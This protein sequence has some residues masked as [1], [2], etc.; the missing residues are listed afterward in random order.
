MNKFIMI[1]PQ[2][3]GKGTQSKLLAEEFGFIHISIGDIFRWNVRNHTK[4]GSRVTRITAE[5][6]LVSDEIVENVV[7]ERLE[8]HD[9]RYGFV[10]D[11]F[12]RTP[13]QAMY[14]FENWNLDRAIYLNLD[15]ETVRERVMSRAKVGE[16]SGFTKRA[17]DNPE[18]LQRR[19]AEYHDKTR[20]LLE[21]FA[22]RDLLL[23]V[24]AGGTIEE[25]FRSV[26]GGLGLKAGSTVP[27][28]VGG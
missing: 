19:L 3:S 25:V 13:S 9:W 16:G 5:G 7:R 14:L 18:A 15:D 12:P 10:L 21:L 4:L 1:G 24:D 20:P 2:G 23:R 17:D 28:L 26:V 22:E 6:R 8:L 11:G 27:A